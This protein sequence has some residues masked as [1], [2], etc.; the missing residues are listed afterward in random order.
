MVNAFENIQNQD[1]VCAILNNQITSNSCSHAYLFVGPVGCGK[2]QCAKAF[3]KALIDEDLA[4]AIER[5]TAPDVKIYEPE[6]VQTYLAGQIKEIVNDSSKAPLVAKKKIYII[7]DAEKLSS[8]A[9]NAF[10]KTLE[11][12]QPYDVFVLLANNVSNVLPTI[13]SRCQ[14][15]NFNN[16]SMQ[17]ALTEIS[18]Q[19][20]AAQDDCKR[21]YNLFG[22]DTKTAIDFCLDQDMQD[23]VS[24]V[25]NIF[26]NIHSLQNWDL[27]LR[28]KDLTSKI[29]E[30]T[31][32]Q[33]N[34]LDAELKELDEVMEKASLQLLEKQNKRQVAAKEKQL[35]LLLTADLS[36]NLRN[37]LKDSYTSNDSNR[38]TWQT[39]YI[40]AMNLLSDFSKKLAYNIAVQN[41]CDVVLLK[42]K[43]CLT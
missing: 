10:L 6:G 35:L 3:A 32:K 1:Q 11:E 37:C 2:L 41:F 15:L 42:T 29:T 40:Q 12:P 5:G 18:K 20:G 28:S 31:K 34:S 19:T 21:A 33:K 25:D 38:E 14:V 9:A 4:E 26:A 43:E 30:I 27:L 7:N 17:D 39:K 23:F 16:V 22:G 24:E 13:T 36:Y 8:S